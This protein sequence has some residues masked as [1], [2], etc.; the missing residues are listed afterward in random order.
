MHGWWLA[1]ASAL[2][3][4]PYPEIARTV[5]PL[6]A[7]VAPS[8]RTPPSPSTMARQP[9]PEERLRRA[10][11]FET[12][13]R[14]LRRRV[15]AGRVLRDGGEQPGNAPPG[16][17]RQLTTCGRP[18]RRVGSRAASTAASPTHSTRSGS[19]SRELERRTA[20]DGV[21]VWSPA[22]AWAPPSLRW[23]WRA[24]T[25]RPRTYPRLF[26]PSARPG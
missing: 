7:T 26:T 14:R 20:G 5:G 1:E 18:S 17:A 8:A 16:P 12:R 21:K 23:R 13:L 6:V 19:R 2:A 15:R 22:T 25:P 10:D 3:Y 9:I 24:G 11:R 4:H